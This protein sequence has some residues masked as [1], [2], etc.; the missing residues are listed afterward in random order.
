MHF[1][2][3]LV[4]LQGLA[5]AALGAPTNKTCVDPLVRKEWYFI[6]APRDE[7]VCVCVLTV[8]CLQE[9]AFDVGEAV[10]H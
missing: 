3:C 2:A 7:C 8:A 6:S 1:L 5:L 10:V 9:T 4:A